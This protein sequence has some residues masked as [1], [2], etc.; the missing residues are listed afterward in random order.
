MIDIFMKVRYTYNR[1]KNIF[2]LKIFNMQG[3]MFTK[4][5]TLKKQNVNVHMEEKPTL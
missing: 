4:I 5:V 1:L 2:K 3:Q